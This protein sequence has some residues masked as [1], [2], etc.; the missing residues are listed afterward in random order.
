[1]RATR[2]A[3]AA[4]ATGS[5]VL[6]MAGPALAA[7]AQDGPKAGQ[8]CKKADIGKQVKLADGTLLKCVLEKGQKVP[9]WVDVTGQ[10]PPTSPP[11]EPKPTFT[12]GFDKVKLS[13]RVVAPGR[14]TTFTVTCP[15]TV[16]ITSNGYT[17]NPLPVTK[18]GKA[19]WTAT[20]TFKSSLPDPTVATV[21]CKGF[22]SVKYSTHPSKTPGKPGGGMQPAKPKIPN[23]RI[24]TGDGSMYGRTAGS[25]APLMAIG[26]GALAAAGLGAVALRARRTARE[27]S[28]VA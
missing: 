3:A 10:Q 16:T 22:G 18:T 24:D 28:D 1:M 13:S 27:R 7:P 19:T 23:G 14:H 2:L 25:G 17:R 26:W 5:L 12:F 6:G 11:T 21:V 20:G 4:V 8:F 9:H 15:S